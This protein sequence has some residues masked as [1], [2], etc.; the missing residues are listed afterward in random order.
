[1]GSSEKVSAL[2]QSV[3]V[4]YPS[5]PIPEQSCGNWPKFQPMYKMHMLLDSDLNTDLGKMFWGLCGRQGEK[6]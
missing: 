5:H 4:V 1:M 3:Q 6:M 2:F